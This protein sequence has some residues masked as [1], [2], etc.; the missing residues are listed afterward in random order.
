MGEA[1]MSSLGD[2]TLDVYL[3]AN[4]LWRNV[5]P[6][7]WN[8]SLGR[9]QVL[10][11]WLSYRENKILGRSLTSDE[12]WYFTETARRIAAVLLANQRL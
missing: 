10:K 8:Y 9:Y 2:V 6:A 7:V 5:P 4:A 12:V 3:N 11:K 1:R